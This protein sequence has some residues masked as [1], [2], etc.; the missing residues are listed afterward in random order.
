MDLGASRRRG[1]LLAV[2]LA[3]LALAWLA[4]AAGA[5]TYQVIRT[6]DAAGTP[7]E[8]DC[9]GAVCTLRQAVIV[10]NNHP[11]ADEI[12]LAD[13][14][15]TLTI[16]G[17][18]G[19]DHGDLDVTQNLDIVG[20]GASKTIINA[21]GSV[22]H[23][24]A[25]DLQSETLTLSGVTVEGG[26][27][28]TEGGVGRGG[29]IRVQTNLYLWD[30]KILGNSLPGNNGDAGGGIYNAGHAVLTRSEVTG[31]QATTGF[32]GG[33]YTT[34]TGLTEI[35]DSKFFDNHAEFGGGLASAE[36][37]GNVLVERSQF[38]YNQAGDLGGA[39]YQLG[40]SSYSFTNTTI[41]GSTA[42]AGNGGGALR[43]RDGTATIRSSTITRNNAPNGGGISAQQDNGK[44]ASVTLAN[45]ILAGNTDTDH[46]DGDSPDCYDPNALVATHVTSQGYNIVG[47]LEGCAFSAVTGDQVGSSISPVDPKLDP[48]EHFNGGPLIRAFTV[49]LLPGSP[50]INAGNPGTEDGVPPHCP[51]TDARGVPRSTGGRCDIGA[52]E[53]VKCHGAVV[54]RVGT[55]GNDSST[56]PELGWTTGEDGFLGLDGNDSLK[57]GDGNDRLCGG[58]GND[59]LAGQDGDDTV[60]G[61]PGDD[62]LT[63]TAGRDTL[64]GGTGRDT[65]KGGTGADTLKGGKGKDHLAGGPGRDV[66]VGGSGRDSAT[67]CEVK[68]GIP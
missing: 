24:R 60:A 19:A 12:Q 30:S 23:D 48:S 46:S 63:G 66:C 22:T 26:I 56:T 49:A 6:D 38:S 10:A 40:S 50:A 44:T 21:N 43:V 51:F 39:S 16:P 58:G 13:G 15:Y 37:G 33:V 45:T 7:I 14:T 29:G 52:Y 35:R 27:A 9:S 68:R 47:R 53:L 20:E 4:P 64:I 62:V 1:H 42:G 31:N 61:D 32:G 8:P 3:G 25:F 28:P 11:G 41:N 55:P 5:Q 59:I 34:A 57:G 65:L 17:G 67:G 36:N 18:G 2:T 54:N